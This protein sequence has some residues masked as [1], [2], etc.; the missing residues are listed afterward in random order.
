MAAEGVSASRSPVFGGSVPILRVESLRAS[1]E[2]YVAVL[3][4]DVDWHD[5]GIIAG[6]SRGRCALMLC[7]GDQGHHGTWVWIGVNDVEPLFAEYR[8]SGASIRQP[9][10]NYP[11]A[12]EL[13]VEDTDGH[14][15]RFGSEP[16]PD[17]PYGEWLDSRGTR[18]TWVAGAWTRAGHADED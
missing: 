16:K 11:W 13:Q 12:Y 7:E 5:P 17:R 14:V 1:L 8:A 4:F 10:T 3:G 2:Y 6:V 9:P 18:W 15:L